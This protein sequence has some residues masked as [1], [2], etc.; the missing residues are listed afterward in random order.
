MLATA[1]HETAYTLAPIA[2]GGC[3]DVIGCTAITN[4]NG[5]INN[6]DYGDPV[7]CPNLALHPPTP[8]PNSNKKK[9]TYYGRGFVQLTSLPNYRATSKILHDK[10]LVSSEDYLVHY[11]EKVM[12]SDLAYTII[13]VGL[14]DEGSFFSGGKTFDDYIP[15]N[16]PATA[17][18]RLQ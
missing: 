10:G 6:R 12:E 11:P 2:E 8:C 3:D 5:T 9:H 15:L 16:T 17:A 18:Q 7:P 14:R 1:Y 13:S 4:K